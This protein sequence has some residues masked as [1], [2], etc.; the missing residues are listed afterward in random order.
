MPQL[1]PSLAL[2]EGPTDY[3]STSIWEGPSGAGKGA[4]AH[5]APAL[6]GPLD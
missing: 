6:A 3:P 1:L 5:Q 2:P 4:T